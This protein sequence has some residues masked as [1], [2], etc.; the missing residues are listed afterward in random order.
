MPDRRPPPDPLVLIDEGRECRREAFPDLRLE[1]AGH[2]AH[3][4]TLGHLIEAYMLQRLK[5]HGVSPSDYRVL[6]ALLLAVRGERATPQVLNHFTRITSAGMTRTLDRLEGAGYLARV[7][8]PEDRRSVLV[9]LTPTG[10]ELAESVMRDVQGHYAET[11]EG[12]ADPDL[13]G[14][15]ETLR[16]IIARLDRATANRR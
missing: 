11:L 12:L 16:R 8:N 15:V 10:R 4:N 3:L 2:L 1:E 13:K 5:P 6:T 7:P 9:E 14:E